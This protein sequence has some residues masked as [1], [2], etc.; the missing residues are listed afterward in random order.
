MAKYCWFC[1]KIDILFKLSLL[2]Q[3]QSDLVPVSENL[4][5]LIFRVFEPK[6]FLLPED[7]S[8]P[9]FKIKYQTTTV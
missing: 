5:K 1:T 7:I 8:A 4:S 2:L 6:L 3:N 9:I